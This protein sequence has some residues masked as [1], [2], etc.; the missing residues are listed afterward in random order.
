MK[1]TLHLEGSKEEIAA[2]VSEF[3]ES[4]GLSVAE[5][6]SEETPK[7]KRGRGR[8]KA[9]PA[10]EPEEE[11]DDLEPDNDDDD[12]GSIDDLDDDSELEDSEEDGEDVDD[13]EEDGE[14][15]IEEDDE[16]AKV[17]PKQLA[18]LKKALNTFAGKNGKAKAVKIL[19]KYAK[20][21]QDVK[22]SDF[23]KIMKELKV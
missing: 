12:E 19:H 15:E 20:V 14:E 2:Q 6:S 18:E 21:S 3:I 10:P 13:L 11:M 5:S 9:Q 1:V 17:S 8:K 22:A 4:L 23:A 7:P 16:P